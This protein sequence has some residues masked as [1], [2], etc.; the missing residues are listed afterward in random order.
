MKEEVSHQLSSLDWIYLHR[1]LSLAKLGSTKVFPNPQVGAVI[2]HQNRIIGEGF[3]S[4]AGGPHAE[5]AAL[6][7]VK[8]QDLLPHSTMYVSLEPCSHHGRTPPCASAIIQ[9]RIPH[10]VIG[11]LDPNPQVS[12]NGLC[13]LQEAG[14]QVQVASDTTAFKS[15]N[16]AFFV[17][18]RFR[19]P[20]IS[21]KWAES[22]DGF[23]AGLGA[24]RHPIRTPISGAVSKIWVHKLRAQSQTIMIGRHTAIIDNPSLTTR[25]Y[26][27]EHP[28]RII[29]D[30]HLQLPSH[31]ALF[32]DGI[33][34]IILNQH[35]QEQ[36]Q[37]IQYYIPQQWEQMELLMKE[38]YGELGICNILVEGGRN[39]LQQFLD[40]D[41]WDE[42]WRFQGPSDLKSGIAAPSI[43]GDWEWSN[44]RVGEDSLSFVSRNHHLS[45]T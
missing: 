34:T 2:V 4:Y 8:Q 7:S 9:H 18:Q 44:Q 20:W 42:L 17:N 25:H 38:L 24:N 14:I 12:G 28:T 45:S 41:I 35:K 37:H 16:K 6:Q 19:R 27:G 3:H 31:L 36:V 26:Y 29:F 40:Q 39:L 15:L 11:C 22:A 33:P 23:I 30:K 32:T 5:I 10:V 43:H 1:C 13:R 21:L